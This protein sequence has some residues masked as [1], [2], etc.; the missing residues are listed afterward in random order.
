MLAKLNGI[1]KR[2]AHVHNSTCSH[3]IANKLL[4]PIMDS[5]VTDRLAC[6]KLAKDWLFPKRPCTVLNNA[7]DIKKYEYSKAIRKEYRDKFNLDGKFVVGHIGLVNNQKNHSLLMEIFAEIKKIKK[8]C[9]LMLI[10]GSEKLT[11]SLK[12]KA[13]RL[14]IDKDILFLNKR[15]D[16][17]NLLQA[18]DVFV[19]PS[20]FEGLGLVLIEAQASSL[21]CVASDA[22]PPETKVTD[23]IEYMSLDLSAEQWAKKAISICADNNRE[24]CDVY[25]DIEKAGYSIYDNSKILRDIYIGGE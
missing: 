7:I 2:I 5:F 19:F 17:H 6:S 12:E 1:P 15:N 25:K 3:K 4:Q 14:G 21:C 11:E 20:L 18:M 10:S 23:L 16:V 24:T 22:V 8:N 13:K 9:I